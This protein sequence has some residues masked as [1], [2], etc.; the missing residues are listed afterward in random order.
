MDTTP[1]TVFGISLM[2]TVL[3][4]AVVGTERMFS[5]TRSGGAFGENE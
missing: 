3:D 4:E 5:M 2:T 1:R